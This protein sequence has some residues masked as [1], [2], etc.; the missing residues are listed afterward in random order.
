MSSTDDLHP[1]SNE[2]MWVLEVGNLEQI[3]LHNNIDL[4]EDQCS[5]NTVLEVSKVPSRCSFY[6]FMFSLCD[7]A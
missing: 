1:V 3:L 5:D 6:F 4:L 7:E 2:R